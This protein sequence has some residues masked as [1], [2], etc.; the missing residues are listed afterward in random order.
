MGKII[1]ILVTGEQLLFYKRKIIQ[2][3]CFECNDENTVQIMK[4]QYENNVIC[5]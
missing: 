5:K 4:I 1:Y 3:V 2:E